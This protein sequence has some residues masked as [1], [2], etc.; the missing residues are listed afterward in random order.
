LALITDLSEGGVDQALEVL[1]LFTSEKMSKY[2]LTLL[3]VDSL[4]KEMAASILAYF[5]PFYSEALD[6][7]K[8][9]SQNPRG[10]G[11]SISNKSI[12]IDD[13]IDSI[14][15]PTPIE[16]FILLSSLELDITANPVI[17]K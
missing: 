12:D 9:F 1:R 6:E 15:S 5:Y 17:R 2:E 8:K 4:G 13:I 3:M 11:L 16:L 7:L 10:L 14:D